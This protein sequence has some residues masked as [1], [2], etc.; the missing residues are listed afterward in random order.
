MI[1]VIGPDD[2]GNVIVKCTSSVGKSDQPIV[3]TERV[4]P[5][6]REMARTVKKLL[7]AM[8]IISKYG[9][10]QYQYVQDATGKYTNPFDMPSES[11]DDFAKNMRDS[12]VKVQKNKDALREMYAP[13][14]KNK[15]RI[16]IQTRQQ[17]GTL[18]YKRYELRIYSRSL[19]PQENQIWNKK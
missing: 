9:L 13:K 15:D 14:G 5:Q 2:K 7:T 6:I 19:K 1:F 11:L 16:R 17:G 12:A 10:D 18:K 4:P 8:S 3:W